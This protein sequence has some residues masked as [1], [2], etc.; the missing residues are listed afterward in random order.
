MGINYTQL[1][2]T[3]KRLIGSNGTKGILL[4]PSGE[5]GEY[6]PATD[7][8]ENKY[9]PFEGYCVIT[10]YDEKLVDGT[11]IKAGDRKIIAVLPAEPIQG[12]SK[13]EVYNKK[14][15][16]LA[17][18]YNIINCTIVNPDMSVVIVYKL[19]CRK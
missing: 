15:G 8:I 10:G 4:N 2:A 12:T 3:A 9:I 16:I 18:T 19:H 14:T 5:K 11:V 6:N 1:C 17:D 13:I 7:E